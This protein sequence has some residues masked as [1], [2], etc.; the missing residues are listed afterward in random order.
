[1]SLVGEMRK[2]GQ[3]NVNPNLPANEP[4]GRPLRETFTFR[5]FEGLLTITISPAR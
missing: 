5:D 1:M 3:R 4:P 2:G